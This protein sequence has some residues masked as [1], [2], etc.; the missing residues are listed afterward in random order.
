M[1]FDFY[2]YH[3]MVLL[4]F[5]VICCMWKWFQLYSIWSRE[6]RD[7]IVRRSTLELRQHF[8]YRFPSKKKCNCTVPFFFLKDCTVPFVRTNTKVFD[9]I[10]CF[11][12][13]AR[14]IISFKVWSFKSLPCNCTVKFERYSIIFLLLGQRWMSLVLFIYR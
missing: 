2:I 4:D 5:P 3:N 1:C 6:S 10:Q 9:I 13:V 12:F 8:M 11:N 7:L 14:S